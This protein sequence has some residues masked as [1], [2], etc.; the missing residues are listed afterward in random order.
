V[1]PA[2]G[3][4]RRCL[5][6]FD[7]TFFFFHAVSPPFLGHPGGRNYSDGHWFPSF[8]PF[9]SGNGV[10]TVPLR[11]FFP[12]PEVFFLPFPSDTAIPPSDGLPLLLLSLRL[13]PTIN[14]GGG[15]LF[16]TP[17]PFFPSIDIRLHPTPLERQENQSSPHRLFTQF[18]HETRHGFPSPF[19]SFNGQSANTRGND[20]SFSADSSS[21]APGRQTNCSPP[22][23]PL[24]TPWQRK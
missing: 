23:P 3:L 5:S 1:R 7:K 21:L 22:P 16:F 19:F 14:V 20:L 10:G 15:T 18:E 11:S 12:F 13:Q 17:L 6:D 8:S 24:M 9:R 4:Q 2:V